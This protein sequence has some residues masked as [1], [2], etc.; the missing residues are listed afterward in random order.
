MA[1]IMHTLILHPKFN[2][3]VNQEQI[4]KH[5]NYKNGKNE[6]HFGVGRSG[7]SAV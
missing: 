4:H 6:S 3:F 1:K 2:G 7:I 5:D